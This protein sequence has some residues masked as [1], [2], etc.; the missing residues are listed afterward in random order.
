[1]YGV[2]SVP[3]IWQRKTEN[4]LQDIS[5]VS[6]FLD[7]IKLTEPDKETHLHLLEQ[8]L[9]RLADSNIRINKEK[10]EFFKDSIYI[11]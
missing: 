5:G 8:V 1:M 10:S 6:V 11:Y 2:V 9:Q 7:D 4:V 3:T